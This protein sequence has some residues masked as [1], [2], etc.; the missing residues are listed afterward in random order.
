MA[1]ADILYFG[2]LAGVMLASTVL[3]LGQFL[4]QDL[5]G[6]YTTTRRLRRRALR[7]R[8]SPVTARMPRGHHGQP[9][10]PQALAR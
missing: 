10:S 8:Q 7:P 2:L 1:V 3:L 9:G 4:R 5:A 6:G